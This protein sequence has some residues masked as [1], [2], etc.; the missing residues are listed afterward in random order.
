MLIQCGPLD[1]INLFIIYILIY[2]N[3]AI[4]IYKIKERIITSK[5]ALEMFI[6]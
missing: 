3:W 5:T 6:Q 2:T 4:F 1:H